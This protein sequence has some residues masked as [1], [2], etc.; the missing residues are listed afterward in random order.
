MKKTIDANMP[1]GKLK[2]IADFLPSPDELALPEDKIKV[3][4]ELS[5]KS[6][7]FFKQE[8]AKRHTKYQKMIRNLLDRYTLQHS[9]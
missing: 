6:V 2:K 3:T 5:N 1:V 8:A 9:R 7:D 4:I